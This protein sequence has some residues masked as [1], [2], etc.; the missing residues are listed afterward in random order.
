MSEQRFIAC[1]A[2]G[3]TASSDAYSCPQCGKP[4]R[5]R[6][7]DIMAVLYLGGT[8]VSVAIFAMLGVAFF[9]QYAPIAVGVVLTV[10]LI[11]GSWIVFRNRARR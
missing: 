4:F 6:P 2:C 5:T 11:V 10:A 3:A 1:P 8:A 7:S 9:A